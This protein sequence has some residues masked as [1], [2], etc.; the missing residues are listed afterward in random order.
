[1]SFLRFRLLIP[2]YYGKRTST[3]CVDSGW[4]STRLQRAN[5]ASTRFKYQGLTLSSDRSPHE[6]LTVESPEIWRFHQWN[7][8]P[9]SNILIICLIFSLLSSSVFAFSSLNTTE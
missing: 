7:F 4:S 2:H 3:A 5:R 6:I 9:F 8:L 1:M